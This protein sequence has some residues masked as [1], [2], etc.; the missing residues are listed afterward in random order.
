MLLMLLL[1]LGGP[2]ETEGWIALS[3]DGYVVTRG[4]GLNNGTLV[5]GDM[6]VSGALLSSF[7]HT[8]VQ[9]I[10]SKAATPREGD[11]LS[12]KLTGCTADRV[13]GLRW[14][15]SKDLE[16]CSWDAIDERG[17]WTPVRVCDRRCGFSQPNFPEIRSQARGSVM[18]CSRTICTAS[19]DL[20]PNLQASS[21]LTLN[22]CTDMMDRFSQLNLTELK[23]RNL[24]AADIIDHQLG[25]AAF[26]G[27]T[28]KFLLQDLQ[29]PQLTNMYDGDQSTTLAKATIMC[30]AK[31]DE[32]CVTYH[33]KETVCERPVDYFPFTKNDAIQKVTSLYLLTIDAV[34]FPGATNDIEF[35]ALELG[36]GLKGSLCTISYENGEMSTIS[37][38]GQTLNWGNSNP[39]LLWRAPVQ[40]DFFYVKEDLTKLKNLLLPALEKIESV[41]DDPDTEIQGVVPTINTHSDTLVQRSCSDY[42]Y[43]SPGFDYLR[44]FYNETG[45]ERLFPEPQTSD[46]RQMP[47]NIS[48]CAGFQSVAPPWVL[49]NRLKYNWMQEGG[50][51]SSGVKN[52]EPENFQ[53]LLDNGTYVGNNC[54]FL[55]QAPVGFTTQLTF[56]YV[57]LGENDTLQIV[58]GEEFPTDDKFQ[59]K[60]GPK[61]DQSKVFFS[62]TGPPGGGARNSSK[63]LQKQFNFPLSIRLMTTNVSS[64]PGFLI[65][66]DFLPRSELLREEADASQLGFALSLLE[67]QGADLKDFKWDGDLSQYVGDKPPGQAILGVMTDAEECFVCC[68]VKDTLESNVELATNEGEEMLLDG[69]PLPL[70]WSIKP[71][72]LSLGT[73]SNLAKHF[74]S[75]V[76]LQDIPPLIAYMGFQPQH[77]VR[78]NFVSYLPPGSI[79]APYGKPLGNRVDYNAKGVADPSIDPGPKT[80]DEIGWGMASVLVE[81]GGNFTDRKT[82]GWG[83]G[84]GVGDAAGK[85]THWRDGDGASDV[86]YPSW[87]LLVKSGLLHARDLLRFDFDLDHPD[88]PLFSFVDENRRIVMANEMALAIPCGAVVN[89]TCGVSCQILGTG[90]NRLQCITNGKKTRCNEPVV[91]ECNNDCGMTGTLECDESLMAL[92]AVRIRS[93]VKD[94]KTSSFQMTVGGQPRARRDNWTRSED[95]SGLGVDGMPSGVEGMGEVGW[96]HSSTSESSTDTVDNA[97]Y[98][99]FDDP[100]KE[101]RD[102]SFSGTA[103]IFGVKEQKL[104]LS[105]EEFRVMTSTPIKFDIPIECNVQ[106][107]GRDAC[108]LASPKN[109][110]SADGAA[111][112]NWYGETPAPSWDTTMDKR[113]DFNEL[114]VVLQENLIFFSIAHIDILGRCRGTAPSCDLK[115][116]ASKAARTLIKIYGRR[117]DNGLTCTNDDF[118]D[119]C[120]MAIDDMLRFLGEHEAFRRNFKE[121]LYSLQ[122]FDLAKIERMGSQGGFEIGSPDPTVEHE[123]NHNTNT[124]RISTYFEATGEYIRLGSSRYLNKTMTKFSS[125][126]LCLYNE[127]GK[128]DYPY[129]DGLFK[130]ESGWSKDVIYFLD[131]CPAGAQDLCYDG[132]ICNITFF[133]WSVEL[134]VKTMSHVFVDGVVDKEIP[135]V[136]RPSHHALH[137]A[138]SLKIETKREAKF[139]RP[140]VEMPFVDPANSQ[141]AKGERTVNLPDASGTIV[142]TG[143][144]AALRR[145]PG[146]RKRSSFT[147]RRYNAANVL[148]LDDSRQIL[149]AAYHYKTSQG[150]H[151]LGCGRFKDGL[152]IPC[153]PLKTVYDALEDVASQLD[154][155]FKYTSD[156]KLQ[157]PSLTTRV[158]DMA[159]ADRMDCSSFRQR[160]GINSTIDTQEFLTFKPKILNFCYKTPEPN[161]VPCRCNKEFGTSQG[162]QCKDCY[163]AS[164]S[165]CQEQSIFG[166]PDLGWDDF[167][168]YKTMETVGTGFEARFEDWVFPFENDLPAVT[169]CVSNYSKT[170]KFTF[171]HMY[172]GTAKGVRTWQIMAEYLNST[173]L[174]RAFSKDKPIQFAALKYLYMQGIA[175]IEFHEAGAVNARGR[176]DNKGRLDLESMWD[177]E[178]AEDYQEPSL[179]N[180]LE[181]RYFLG[182]SGE[183]ILGEDGDAMSQ[184]GFPVT[185]SERCAAC[186][187]FYSNVSSDKSTISSEETSCNYI[188][189]SGF[190]D[191]EA[192]G[193]LYELMEEKSFGS[194]VYKQTPGEYYLHWLP[195]ACT[196]R[197]QCG[198][199]VN[200]LPQNVG[201]AWV[202]GPRVGFDSI[203]ASAKINF[204][205]NISTEELDRLHMMS[206]RDPTSPYLKWYE[207]NKLLH[208]GPDRDRQFWSAV[209]GRS[210]EVGTGMILACYVRPIWQFAST[211]LSFEDADEYTKLSFPDTDGQ[212]VSTGNLEMITS[213]GTQVSPILGRHSRGSPHGESSATTRIKFGIG[214][215]TVNITAEN[216]NV[217]FSRTNRNI[218]YCQVPRS[219]CQ[220]VTH[221]GL[222]SCHTEAAD[223]MKAFDTLPSTTLRNCVF[224]D[225]AP[226]PGQD[227]GVDAVVM[228]YKDRSDCI[229]LF[230]ID[231]SFDGNAKFEQLHHTQCAPGN[232]VILARD[233]PDNTEEQDC[234]A[235]PY[236]DA[237]IVFPYDS[238]K[239]L[240]GLPTIAAIVNPSDNLESICPTFDRTTN[241]L[242]ED[243]RELFRSACTQACARER[244]C[245]AAQ[246][247]LLDRSSTVQSPDVRCHLIFDSCAQTQVMQNAPF[248]TWLKNSGGWAPSRLARSFPMKMS[249]GEKLS[250]DD[251]SYESWEVR[252]VKEQNVQLTWNLTSSRHYRMCA[253]GFVTSGFISNAS[254]ADAPFSRLTVNDCLVS[255]NLE[256]T[257]R[258]ATGV[259]CQ[260]PAGSQWV[261][262]NIAGG[263][264]HIVTAETTGKS[265]CDMCAE[266]AGLP[267]SEVWHMDTEALGC[268]HN[269]FPGSSPI[270]DL[271]AKVGDFLEG[272]T[273]TRLVCKCSSRK[274]SHT[275]EFCPQ[276][277]SRLFFNNK[278]PGELIQ[279]KLREEINLTTTGFPLNVE[280]TNATLLTAITKVRI[281][282]NIFKVLP[283]TSATQITI[284]PIYV[285][286]IEEYHPAGS[287]VY[288]VKGGGFLNTTIEL[289]SVQIPHGIYSLENVTSTLNAQVAKTF[290]DCPFAVSF[291]VVEPDAGLCGET[292]HGA[293]RNLRSFHCAPASRYIELA[294]GLKPDMQDL[295]TDDAIHIM[296]SSKILE[297][298]GIHTPLRAYTFGAV[299]M[300][301]LPQ[302][303]VQ[304]PVLDGAGY[305]SSGYGTQSGFGLGGQGSWTNYLPPT[306]QNTVVHMTWCHDQWG[307]GF[308]CPA[309]GCACSTPVA[310]YAKVLGATKTQRGHAP[311]NNVVH[312]PSSSDGIVLSTGNLEDVF[313]DSSRV[314]GLRINALLEHEKT[315]AMKI[316]GRLEFSSC[317]TVFD[318]VADCSHVDTL[319]S[320]VGADGKLDRTDISIN[321]DSNSSIAFHLWEKQ[322]LWIALNNASEDLYQAAV[323][324]DSN[325]VWSMLPDELDK[326]NKTFSALQDPVSLAKLEPVCEK[327]CDTL[328]AFEEREA[329]NAILS[330]ALPLAHASSLVELTLVD[331]VQLCRQVTCHESERIQ[332]KTIWSM[333][334]QNFTV[335]EYGNAT[336]AHCAASCEIPDKCLCSATVSARSTCSVPHDKVRADARCELTSDDCP[337]PIETH[338]W[339]ATIQGIDRLQIVKRSVAGYH[340][341]EDFIF[342]TYDAE[343]GDFND[344]AGD[345]LAKVPRLQTNIPMCCS[346][347][348][349]LGL[350]GTA[351]DIADPKGSRV[352]AGLKDVLPALDVARDHAIQQIREDDS[353]CVCVEIEGTS[354][355]EKGGLMDV[356]RHICHEVPGISDAMLLLMGDGGSY[357]IP[358]GVCVA[359]ADSSLQLGYNGSESRTIFHFD[360]SGTNS[361]RD[362]LTIPY[363]N[364]MILTSGNLDAVTKEAGS[365]TS[366]HVAG[367]TEIVDVAYIGVVGNPAVSQGSR[368]G[369][370]GTVR[371]VDGSLNVADDAKG[372]CQ[373]TD[374]SGT[375][376]SCVE[377]EVKMV[378]MNNS[379]SLEGTNAKSNLSFTHAVGE[380]AMTFPTWDDDLCAGHMS[381]SCQPRDSAGDAKFSGRIVTTGNLEDIEELS[382]NYFDTIGRVDVEG[383]IELGSGYS[384]ELPGKERRTILTKAKLPRYPYA[385]WSS[386]IAS[387]CVEMQNFDWDNAQT[388]ELPECKAECES[389]LACGAVVL[390]KATDRSPRAVDARCVLLRTLASEC[391]VKSHPGQD[392]HLLVR[393]APSPWF[394]HEGNDALF[395]SLCNNM[396]SNLT[397][398]PGTPIR[399]HNFVGG[400]IVYRDSDPY[401]WASYPNYRCDS[402]KFEVNDPTRVDMSKEQLFWASIPISFVSSTLILN[403]KISGFQTFLKTSHGWTQSQVNA[404]DN[405]FNQLRP[406]EYVDKSLN[407]D[408][409]LFQ[410]AYRSLTNAP[411]LTVDMSHLP[412]AFSLD[413]SVLTGFIGAECIV[414]CDK[415]PDCSTVH[416]YVHS[417]ICVLQAALE[418]RKTLANWDMMAGYCKRVPS[419]D[420]HLHVFKHDQQIKLTFDSPTARHEIKFAD[421]SGVILTT[422]NL[423]DIPNGVGLIG[424]DVFKSATLIRDAG[425]AEGY[426]EWH[427]NEHSDEFQANQAGSFLSGKEPNMIVRGCELLTGCMVYSSASIDDNALEE[428]IGLHVPKKDGVSNMDTRSGQ[429]GVRG[430]GSGFDFFETFV[431]V[432]LP[433]TRTEGE[434]I[435]ACKGNFPCQRGTFMCHS[436]CVG[437]MWPRPGI[438]VLDS[439]GPG[440]FSGSACGCANG[441]PIGNFGTS[442]CVMT[443]NAS[444]ADHGRFCANTTHDG[445]EYNIFECCQDPQDTANCGQCVAYS[446]VIPMGLNQRLTLPEGNGTIITTG[447]VDD[448]KLDK[449]K[450]EGLY[451]VSF[452]NF[453]NQFPTE[454]SSTPTSGG[455][456]GYRYSSEFDLWASHAEFDPVSTRISGAFRFAS[457][458]GHPDVS[459]PDLR[460]GGDPLFERSGTVKADPHTIFDI[461]PTTL[462]D[463]EQALSSLPEY[464]QRYCVESEAYHYEDGRSNQQPAQR[465][466]DVGGNERF[467]A[468][469]RWKR[470]I[471]MPDVTGKILTTGNLEETPS[472]SISKEDLILASTESKLKVWGN[473][474]WGRRVNYTHD[475]FNHHYNHELGEIAFLEQQFQS[476]AQMFTRINGDIGLTFQSAGEEIPL[477]S[478][479]PTDELPDHPSKIENYGSF[480]GPSPFGGDAPTDE[481]SRFARDGRVGD[482][483]NKLWNEDRIKL[484]VPLGGGVDQALRHFLRDGAPSLPVT[485]QDRMSATSDADGIRDHFSHRSGRPALQM[486]SPTYPSDLDV[487]NGASESVAPSLIGSHAINETWCYASMQQLSLL[488]TSLSRNTDTT[489]ST[490]ARHLM[491][492]GIIKQTQ[493]YGQAFGSPPFSVDLTGNRLDK[494]GCKAFI[495]DTLQ[496]VRGISQALYKGLEPEILIGTEFDENGN[497][498]EVSNV[499]QS[500]NIKLYENKSDIQYGAAPHC[501]PIVYNSSFQDVRVLQFG[502]GCKEHA[503][504]EMLQNV[505][506]IEECFVKCFELS[507]GMCT[508]IVL[509][510]SFVHRAN[511]WAGTCTFVTRDDSPKCTLTSNL[512][513]LKFATLPGTNYTA[514]NTTL[515][516]QTVKPVSRDCRPGYDQD[517]TTPEF[518]GYRNQYGI[519]VGP[520]LDGQVS[521]VEKCYACCVLNTSTPELVNKAFD[522]DVETYHTYHEATSAV[523]AID[524]GPG[525]ASV[526]TSI[527]FYPRPGYEAKMVGG[528]FQGSIISELEGYEDLHVIQD[529][530]PPREF[531]MVRLLNTNAFRWLRYVGPDGTFGDVTEIEFH[532]GFMVEELSNLQSGN[533]SWNVDGQELRTA[534]KVELAMLVK[535]AAHGMLPA[536]LSTNMHEVLLPANPGIVITTGNLEDITK[537]SSVFSSVN[538]A[539]RALMEG[540][541]KLGDPEL[542]TML[543]VNTAVYGLSFR[544]PLIDSNSVLSIQQSTN[545]VDS[546]FSL[547]DH[548]GT[549]VLG[550]LPAV[551]SNVHVLA[552]GGVDFDWSVKFD[553]KVKFG[554]GTQGAASLDIIAVLGDSFPLSFGGTFDS[555]RKVSI[556][557]PQASK[558]SVVTLPDATGTI[559]T[560]GSIP[561]VVGNISA[562]DHTILQGG[563]TFNDFD[564]EIGEQGLDVGLHLN[565]NIM[566]FTSLTFDGTSRKDGRTL[567][568]SAADPES[569]NEIT[570]PDT[571]GTVIT[572]ANFPSMFDSLRTLGDLEIMGNSGLDSDLIRIGGLER[573]SHVAFK[574][575]ISGKFPL[576]FDGGTTN[577]A[578][579]KATQTTTLHVPQTSR[580]NIITFPDISGTVVT[581]TSL[582]SRTVTAGTYTIDATQLLVSG[583]QTSM[584]L[585]SKLSG[586]QGTFHFADT[587]ARDRANKPERD[588]QFM[589]HALGGVNVITG[590]TARGKDTGAFLR[591]GSSAWYYVSDRD[592]KTLLHEVNT[593]AIVAGLSNIPVHRWRYSGNH[594]GHL[595]LGPMAQDMH[596][597]FSLGE[598][599]DRISASDADGVALAAIK[600]LYQKI[601]HLNVTA[602]QYKRHLALQ[603]STIM[604]QRAQLAS[605]DERLAHFAGRIERLWKVLAGQR[606]VSRTAV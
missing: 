274:T 581:S 488:D 335:L 262:D 355:K 331:N 542:D 134:D 544:G 417:R 265:C 126:V 153:D 129:G 518:D 328:M 566:G 424:R 3:K 269:V 479:A 198:T 523:V 90:L 139:G 41:W 454:Q 304:H 596:S 342:T 410:Q 124:L 563:V 539:D 575:H 515:L 291:T 191:A 271:S 599:A 168:S 409:E 535:C 93:L 353:R 517:Y 323:Y 297:T 185:D 216:D 543:E 465:G 12:E 276:S 133:E 210:V 147:P 351:P 44:V 213:L 116:D 103:N 224:V 215:Q 159:T 540:S 504:S 53:P 290:D 169:T 428:K 487:Y 529:E 418:Q 182:L 394:A 255:A 192:I 354:S 22:V 532:H 178:D 50:A 220:Y 577:E 408:V 303:V 396:R 273:L 430:T 172:Y 16:G 4:L 421:T 122:R 393:E 80:R 495:L 460:P 85:G 121:T 533:V 514:Y 398:V 538:V 263:E 65:Y 340:R 207:H 449:V 244:R 369:V 98:L 193:G 109:D 236:W 149:G 378:V 357:Q 502:I 526:I 92:G 181:P 375:D 346:V 595:H 551:M 106:D 56:K 567:V 32:D 591:P 104:T 573:L 211:M 422:G 257:D 184:L 49:Y 420:F 55:L 117:R 370:V 107:L 429:F 158:P 521:E 130:L 195:L 493:R 176:V 51:I 534:E 1:S 530:P 217:D 287:A 590:K 166:G 412:A 431:D 138:T 253:N 439:C 156:L 584:G 5:E 167:E 285:W 171:L 364:G 186:C 404:L 492:T 471:L 36:I 17:T 310:T 289:V 508:G 118:G 442:V 219:S 33:D 545:S 588:N 40:R 366:L 155:T 337:K 163:A 15:T 509:S 108:K 150:N 229:V 67:M 349:A 307:P 292:I 319:A 344:D 164:F 63:I 161:G 275:K 9:E 59:E 316:N 317:N 559:L 84:W 470:E 330:L 381:S 546:I 464:Q 560:T 583:Q 306:F 197:P 100:A 226:I 144:L 600:G 199:N 524:L 61:F 329:N 384:C 359:D 426:R 561:R 60:N 175:S 245:V 180:S 458:Y 128:G 228:S 266:Y 450:L 305:V 120:Y 222:F 52:F 339:D 506:N 603:Q 456:S 27:R 432:A 415:H 254:I 520:G 142:T 148:T 350:T 597:A 11:K 68:S 86:W 249:V 602:A 88:L 188:N 177:N 436:D 552:S 94:D 174:G 388:L 87:Q 111:P 562:I 113:M 208:G 72:E 447:N 288:E 570:L 435:G 485:V 377:P 125:S 452:M 284:E 568:L 527:R 189:V 334:G 196:S 476:S 250:I 392:L 46:S 131:T 553:D 483:R 478:F 286:G 441:L 123:Y 101:H 256:T 277:S 77:F 376:A 604:E 372:H 28:G 209:Q 531:A 66:Y 461:E 448:L 246:P 25:A 7:N 299:S 154:D 453:G 24:T 469:C 557:S 554:G 127:T 367:G 594:S 512:L 468:R 326:V 294:G 474:S 499:Y 373:G 203:V 486:R 235:A 119:N 10:I 391:T 170:S 21:L 579:S 62:F 438:D 325:M 31:D 371:T 152:P 446:P 302:R 114:S 18:D 173:R 57:S 451:L 301:E 383:P 481:I 549:L 43:S 231:E 341:C 445:T 26:H 569:N 525:K 332:G 48:Q 140:W 112:L 309:S 402:L 37:T 496:K 20:G 593:S 238:C 202:I 58:S 239:T 160:C 221:D 14:S 505:R 572:T 491:T 69:A 467:P 387:E 110:V 260:C 204:W 362:Y 503:G 480:F 296:N 558:D 336:F 356:K 145:M 434:C 162:A 582:P 75:N 320:A 35:E 96:G 489:M 574:A 74:S 240:D 190:D 598:H 205:A 95:I 348:Y 29:V 73:S 308:Q 99:S 264:A 564:V 251:L 91:D 427:L 232:T 258:L 547:P 23:C 365:I 13:G 507:S 311:T 555:D 79:K 343:C 324:G 516:A 601:S 268:K 333:K 389:D 462:F 443:E 494:Q 401:A 194:R 278:Q 576:V 537:E 241:V 136:F 382:P 242:D 411:D 363:T 578:D 214:W 243:C 425:L 230:E 179:V 511:G 473:I 440:G 587:F 212:L 295:S 482:N 19:C 318:D 200:D 252:E 414:A 497:Q 78:T 498:F 233:N 322:T 345:C 519:S 314:T 416:E 466:R 586:H 89:N 403:A 97:L 437:F 83:D 70:A 157:G 407:I 457:G 47:G 234:N 347:L 282:R 115:R 247:F 606:L 42:N 477:I 585:S 374:V 6:L 237:T 54:T 565:A 206:A 405:S 132:G 8:Y 270:Y 183:H 227:Y 315:V 327:Y 522:N 463:E 137:H 279:G 380:W 102:V 248:E 30:V 34:R 475:P 280:V 423:Y 39:T 592:A 187:D 360:P 361:L 225:G 513:E 444:H 390:K 272:R 472:I 281:G 385:V 300:R 605:Q 38:I 571:S 71:Y 589:A 459:Y 338:R 141:T 368:W 261:K 379:I 259:T 528:K 556:G 2:R 143:N 399:F 313:F 321:L 312:V 500:L 283:S 358:S 151:A 395:A 82:H 146:L 135:F 201:P 400:D 298:L 536:H 293:S 419:Q 484:N 510:K 218:S 352:V 45:W 81:K 64:A 223:S 490:F 386:F 501:G 541:V 433:G 105:R 455:L 267:V 413:T 580:H 76:L 548:S 406:S 550:D 397:H 165:F